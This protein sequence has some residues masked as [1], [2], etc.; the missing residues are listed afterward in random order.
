MYEG[1]VDSTCDAHP[2]NGGHVLLQL[3]K[4]FPDRRDPFASRCENRLSAER[5]LTAGLR[6]SSSGHHCTRGVQWLG[7]APD[8]PVCV[9]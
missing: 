7:T 6:L 8:S 2:G 1:A 3:R 5:H 4:Q 9:H